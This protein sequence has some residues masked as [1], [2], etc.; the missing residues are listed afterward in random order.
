MKKNNGYPET[1]A[2]VLDDNM[3]FLPGTNKVMEEFKKSQPWKGDREEIQAK[4]RALNEELSTV[5]GIEPPQVIF[6]SRFV[7]GSCYFSIGNLIILEQEKDGRYSVVVFLHEFGHALGKNEKATCKWSI[8]LFKRHFPRSFNKL[9][10]KGHLLM[11][12][13]TEKP[14]ADVVQDLFD[15][16]NK[17]IGEDHAQTR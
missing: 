13:D 2:E 12:N 14:L 10:P 11:R 4:F 1:V 5:Y 3:K 7:Y 8:N 9:I 15:N 6:V 16:P 17:Y